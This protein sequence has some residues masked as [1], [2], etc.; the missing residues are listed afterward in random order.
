DALSRPMSAVLSRAV[1]VGEA[2]EL[3]AI[4][5]EVE[6]GDVFILRSD[7]LWG[8]VPETQIAARLAAHSPDAACDRLIELCLRAGAPDNV[9][10]V[11][12]ACEQP[13]LLSLTRFPA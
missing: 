13:T 8:V 11:A 7:G 10:L 12:V 9:T 3:D 1:G 5:D 4:A 2:L 6:A